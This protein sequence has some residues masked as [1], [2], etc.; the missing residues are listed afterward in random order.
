MVQIIAGV[1]LIVLIFITI[2]AVHVIIIPLRISGR[3]SSSISDLF[4]VKIRWGFIRASVGVTASGIAT[5]HLYSFCLKEFPI[6]GKGESAGEEDTEEA[7]EEKK[8]FNAENIIPLIDQ[9]LVILRLINFDYLRVNAKIGLGDPCDTGFVYGIG[10]A[11]KGILCCSKG[12]A[13]NIIPV[14]ETEAFDIN[15]EGAFRIKYPWQ[16]ISDIF[17]LYRF[18]I[19][20]K[21]D[22]GKKNIR[23]VAAL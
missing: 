14:F 6:I 3:L 22:K 1:C 2:I 13:F 7:G 19:S 12:F 11:L 15:I 23:S 5:L 17:R 8:Q 4:V 16:I 10:S 18:S 21:K 9:V 20:R